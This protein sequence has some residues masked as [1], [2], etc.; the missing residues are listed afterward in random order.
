MHAASP[1]PNVLGAPRRSAF[2]PTFWALVAL[3][4]VGSGVAAG[5]LMKLLRLVQ[6]LAWHYRGGMFVDAV[7]KAAAPARVLILAGAGL[8]VAV[9][10]IAM[11]R[12]KSSRAGELETT[13]WFRGGRLP[14][15]R[16]A[17]KAL[18]SIV[19]VG[20]GASLGR[21]AAPKQAGTLI[22]ALLAQWREIEPSQ[23]RLLAACGAGAGMAA[24]YNVPLGGALF[25]L[26]VLLGTLALPLVAPAF[27]AS[28][29]A[30]ATAWIFL[31]NQPSYNL[32]AMPLTTSLVVWSVVFAPLAGLA[33][34]LFVKAIAFIAPRRP[35]GWAIAPAAIVVF[36][37]LGALSIAFPQ[38]LGNGKNVVELAA[39][40]R[41]ALPVLA[42]LVLL[43]P[44]ATIGCLWT[45]APG[46]LF[47]PTMAVGA[48]LGGM[49]GHVWLM[50]WP[51]APAGA[52]AILGAGAVLAATTKGPVSALVLMMELSGHIDGLMMPLLIAVAGG[53]TVGHWLDPRSTYTSRLRASGPPQ[54]EVTVSTADRYA[55]LVSIFMHAQAPA[56]I[57]VVDEDSE[58]VGRITRTA[59]EA[60]AAR[61]AP[62]E[63][64]TSGDV[65]ELYP[66]TSTKIA[67]S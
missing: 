40:D 27:V 67:T 51:G 63:I 9:V 61:L 34:A 12:F 4:G 18:L 33:S 16:T 13:I 37:G 49:L 31:P 47:T 55:G 3:T 46:G 21:E 2:P 64:A 50:L 17:V 53:V 23:R 26:E 22:A 36:T 7:D 43:K 28:L 14:P 32:P 11:G 5:L 65:L 57:I 45:G 20:L 1:Q 39:F 48:L 30:V 58:V 41:L 29:L 25:A 10:L 59:V 54:T 19:V 66:G 8:L 44:L 60:A 52:F 42:A 6:H 35:T 38:L 56:A 62:L 15:V 24:V